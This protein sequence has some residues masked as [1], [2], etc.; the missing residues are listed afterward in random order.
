MIPDHNRLE[1]SQC[2]E[3]ACTDLSPAF[4]VSTV[5]TDVQLDAVHISEENKVN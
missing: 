2:T 4:H 1:V 3:W 5:P